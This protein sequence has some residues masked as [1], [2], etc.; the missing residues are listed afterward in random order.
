MGPSDRQLG[1]HCHGNCNPRLERIG[2]HRAA[3]RACRWPIAQAQTTINSLLKEYQNNKKDSPRVEELRL[4]LKDAISQLERGQLDRLPDRAAMHLQTFLEYALLMTKGATRQHV[5]NV[6]VGAL[7]SAKKFAP[8]I[9]DSPPRK[10]NGDAL[11][12]KSSV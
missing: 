10:R 3:A 12:A 7:E 1:G 11:R 5:F 8:L 9:S 4:E 2:V 6:A